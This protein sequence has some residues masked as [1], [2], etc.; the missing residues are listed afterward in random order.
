MII[1]KSEEE[2]DLMRTSGKVTAYILKELENFIKPG[3]S[4]ADIDRFVEETIT[5]R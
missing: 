1:I 3:M 2:I 5:L 4:T